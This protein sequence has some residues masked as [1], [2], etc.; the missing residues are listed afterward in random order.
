[1]AAAPIFVGTPKIWD[2]VLSVANTN[3]DGSGTTATVLS[4]GSL[5]SRID[6]IRVVASG[7]VTAGVIRYIL[8]DGTNKRLYRE[9]LVTAITPSTT[10]AVFEDD[11]TFTDGLI[12]PN[13]WSLLAAT[14]NAEGFNVFAHGGDL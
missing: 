8:N 11:I 14:N 12:I 13:G 3:R 5:G 9:R 10:I 1:M 4:G 7:T 6:R 2:T